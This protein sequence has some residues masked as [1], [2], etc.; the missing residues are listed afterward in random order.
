[1]WA[2]L[3]PEVRQW[4]DIGAEYLTAVGTVGAVIVALYLS[5]K[6]A[7][8]FRLSSFARAMLRKN[9]AHK[10]FT[11]LGSFMAKQPAYFDSQASAAATL[12]M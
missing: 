3:N 4:L 2:L 12:K 8:S 9:F 11:C 1:M 6:G 5:H 10:N 7:P